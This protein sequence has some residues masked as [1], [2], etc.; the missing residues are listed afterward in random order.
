MYTKNKIRNRSLKSALCSTVSGHV[1]LLSINTSVNKTAEAINR[2]AGT[3]FRV[4]YIYWITS[5]TIP[6]K[7][8]AL[9]PSKIAMGA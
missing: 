5:S 2:T 4:V 8:P 3:E 7:K 6:P 9:T 1:G